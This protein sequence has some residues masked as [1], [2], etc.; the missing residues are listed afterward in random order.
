[1]QDSSTVSTPMATATKL[2]KDTGKSVDITNY[3]AFGKENFWNPK[4]IDEGMPGMTAYAGFY[5]VAA[6]KKGEFVFVTY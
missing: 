1:M 3:R 6:P 4:K 2:D 5:E